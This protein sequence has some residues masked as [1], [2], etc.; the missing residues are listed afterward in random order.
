MFVAEVKLENK[1][2]NETIEELKFVLNQ[3]SSV[4]QKLKKENDSKAVIILQLQNE[5][6]TGEVLNCLFK[7]NFYN[8]C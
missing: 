3:N 2:L 6:S 5:L 1:K 8:T 7:T 4:I